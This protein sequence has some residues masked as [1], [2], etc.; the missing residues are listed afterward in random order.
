M[1]RCESYPPCF[2]TIYF[3]TAP[4][5]VLSYFLLSVDMLFYASLCMIFFGHFIAHAPQFLHFS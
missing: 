4:F 1:T 3:P 5:S 2:G